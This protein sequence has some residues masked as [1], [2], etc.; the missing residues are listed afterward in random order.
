MD[1]PKTPIECGLPAKFTKFWE[2][3]VEC[4]D[5]ILNW[6]DSGGHIFL[7]N[8]PTGSGKTIIANTVAKMLTRELGEFSKVYYVVGT[9][10]LQDQVMKD[11][12]FM[13]KVI[14]RSNFTCQ[15]GGKKKLSC[16]E[17]LY[18]SGGLAC[19]ERSMCPY[20]IQKEE[21]MDSQFCVMNYSYFLCSLNYAKDWD[22]ADLIIF[23]ECDMMD[24]ELMKNIGIEITY[25]MFH[26]YE[27]G[28]PIKGD[29]MGR[30]LELKKELVY[31]INEKKP[32][33]Q[34]TLLTGF[35]PD[36]ELVKYISKAE[37]LLKRINF[38]LEHYNED[39]WVI[40]KKIGYNVKRSKVVFKPV[41]LNEFGNFYFGHSNR[42]LCMSATTPPTSVFAR[43]FGVDEKFIKYK[44]V[45][46]SFPKESC[47][48]IFRPIGK[49][50]I[51]HI[52]N[53]M[54]KLLK[55]INTIVE[56]NMYKKILIHTANYRISKEIGDDFVIL[57]KVTNKV[58]TIPVF[59][60]DNAGERMDALNDFKKS[61][62]PAILKSPSFERGVDLPYDEC[63]LQIICKI[64]YLSLG[65]L[66]TKRRM[67]IDKEWYISGTINRLVQACGRGMRAKDDKCTTIVLD[68]CFVLLARKYGY[69]M[70][71]WFK[72]RICVEVA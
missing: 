70:P 60:H 12:D 56:N 29:I 57:D 25:N 33:L 40:D 46:S 22:E 41:I 15:H 47:P 37:K 13:K 9:K 58:I 63:G 24:M 16:A 1:I 14:G 34:M 23:D 32:S 28:F 51:N 27:L 62:A 43:E 69:M 45:A 35:E 10:Q 8:A 7:L 17:G 3:Q 18:C 26:D 50:S 53:N 30:V 21:A 4:V 44:E 36:V 2:G 20:F 55:E 68:E 54:E 64:P 38:V 19:P 61:D 49:M 6:F 31:N 11:F 59:T 5:E 48:I 66:Q 65:D 67:E 42:F 71:D 72:E 39:I 52:D